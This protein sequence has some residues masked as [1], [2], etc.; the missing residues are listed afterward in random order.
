MDISKAFDTVWHEG[1]LFKLKRI[2]IEGD[3]IGIIESFLSD[4]KQRVTID[5][6]FSEWVDVQAG[7]PQGSLLG[8]LLFL[9]FINDLVEV[10]ESDIRIFAD[11]TSFF[12]LLINF[13]Q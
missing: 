6:K 3:M 2:G 12:E 7:V 8:P 9:V 10:V 5:G 13:Q 11:D 1:L 4:R